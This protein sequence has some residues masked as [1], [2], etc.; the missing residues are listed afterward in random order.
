MRVRFVR[1]SSGLLVTEASSA[2][3]QVA[4]PVVARAAPAQTIESESERGLA[5]LPSLSGAGPGGCQ[6]NGL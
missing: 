3:V 5:C 1:A 4:G 2:D 6:P